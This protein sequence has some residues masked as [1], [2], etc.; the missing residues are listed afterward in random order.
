VNA[1]AKLAAYGLVLVGMVGGGAA[2][3][4][5]VGPIDTGDS[6]GEHGGGHSGSAPEATSAAA[7]LPAGGLLVSQ[8]GYTFDPATRTLDA[9]RTNPFSFTITG[10]DGEPLEAYEQLHDRE[11]HLI[12]VSSDLAEFHHVHPTRDEGGAWSINLP[13]LQPGSHRAYADFQPRNGDQLTLG[14]DLTVPGQVAAP[15]KP[16][17]RHT[18]KVD[19]YEVTLSGDPE[20]EVDSE[21]TITVRRDGEVVTTEPYLGAAGHLVAIRDG[22]LAYLHVHPL[23]DEPAGPVRFAVEVP[24][25]G[26]YGLYFD[27]ALDGAIHTAAFTTLIDTGADRG[28]GVADTPSTTDA[29]HD[30][31]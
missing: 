16:E 30:G 28:G 10:P 31:H 22:D 23:D 24:S 6:G 14:I 15:T 11:L 1:G 19:G 12:V 5:A 21:V 18:V 26:T 8:E 2:V 4:A 17:E 20:P 29:G 13:A 7:E 3:G 27:F 9:E 25:A